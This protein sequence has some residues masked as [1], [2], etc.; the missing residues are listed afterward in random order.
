MR[1]HAPGSLTGLYAPPPGDEPE[2]AS[3][4]ASVAV[5][6]GVTVGVSPADE[7]TVTVDGEPAPFEP[8]EG[9]LGELDVDAAVAVEPAVP[10]G[11]G[12][13]ASGAATLATALAANE[14]FDLG[15]D[16]EALVAAAH[17][18]ELAAGTGQGDVFVQARGGLLW[19]GEGDVHRRESDAAI[20]WASAGPVS[21]AD[22]LADEAFQATARRVGPAHLD[23]LA[24]RPTVRAFLERSRAYLEETGL[25]TGFVERE[26]TR[27][28]AA[29]GAASMALFGNTVFGVGAE[30][31][32]ANR[33]AVS[34]RGAR[35][36][37][38]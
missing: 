5:R 36:L 16:R 31:V 34:N 21:T 15:R 33:T 38:G 28:E 10:L 1:A 14:V 9:M 8:V 7:T 12:F 22:L 20:E 13:G 32:L 27:V 4:G 30:G 2:A 25:A 18:A 11:H 17:R 6:D 19:S 37:D 35:L 23:A 3:R 24:D 29:G 26:V